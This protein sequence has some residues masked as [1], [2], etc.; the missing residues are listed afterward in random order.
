MAGL[1]SEIQGST[2]R[3]FL[4]SLC[5]LHNDIHNPVPFPPLQRPRTKGAWEPHAT[6]TGLSNR[7]ASVPLLLVLYKQALEPTSAQSRNDIGGWVEC[8][9]TEHSKSR[10]G[11]EPWWEQELGGGTGEV[12]S[13]RDGCCAVA[14]WLACSRPVLGIY[15][16]PTHALGPWHIISGA[17][18]CL[19]GF[20]MVQGC[21]LGDGGVAVR[22]LVR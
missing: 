17:S 19:C 21:G 15:T 18:I 14:L 8:V 22:V 2:A 5:L 3:A 13:Y 4:Q 7:E 1:P 20:V 11:V 9:W 10:E 6:S 12:R 16:C